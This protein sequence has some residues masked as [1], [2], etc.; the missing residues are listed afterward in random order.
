MPRCDRRT[1]SSPQKGRHA[2]MG[3]EHC[4]D[5]YR[6]GGQTYGGGLTASMAMRE[7]ATVRGLASQ[8]FAS[9]Q[10]ARRRVWCGVVGGGHEAKVP[11]VEYS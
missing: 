9:G 1:G 4:H 3:M 7:C 11:W 8:C 2:G 6:S 5:R 10:L